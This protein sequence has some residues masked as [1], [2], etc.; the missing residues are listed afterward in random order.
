[1]PVM[2]SSQQKSLL[3]TPDKQLQFLGTSQELRSIEPIQESGY[4]QLKPEFDHFEQDP[5]Y[6]EAFEP[7]PVMQNFHR[8]G[9]SIVIRENLEGVHSINVSNPDTEGDVGPDHYFQMVKRSFMIWDKEGNVLYG[10][11]ANKTLWNDYPGPWHSMEWTDPIVIYDHLSDRWLAS[12]M[13]FNLGVEYYEM[14]AVSATADPLGAWHCYSL[15]FDKMPDY[16]KFG[17]WPDGYYLTINEYIITPSYTSFFDG[18]SILVFNRD[19]L[20]NG[21]EDPTVLYFHHE[22]PNQSISE[23]IA[24]FQPSDLDGA[25]PPEGTPNYH[26]C[27]KD[28]DWGFEQDRLWVWECVVDW[29][30]TSNSHFSEVAIIETEP[31][32]TNL[33]QTDI[34]PQPVT[35]TRLHSL[36]HF[37]MYRLQYRNFGDYEALVCN[38]TVQIDGNYHGGIRWYQL[39]DEGSG[40]YIYQQSTYVPD[41]HSRWMASMAMDL[42]GNIAIGYSLSSTEIYPSIMINGRYHYDPLNLLTF[43]ESSVVDGS[44]YQDNIPRWGDYS[45]MSVD[46]TDDFTFWYTQEYLDVSGSL[47][48]KTRVAS[49]QLHRN[50]TFSEDSLVFTTYNECIE[51]KQIIIKNNTDYDIEVSYIEPEGFYTGA[52]WYIDPYVFSFPFWLVPGDSI[53]FMVKVDFPVDDPQ[54][55]YQ[56]DTLDISTGYKEYGIPVHVNDGLMTGLK[57]SIK[58]EEN[59][60]MRV[61]PNPFTSQ[62]TIELTLDRGSKVHLEVYSIEGNL[63][64]NLVDGDLLPAG[65]YQINWE[66]TDLNGT[67]LPAGIFLVKATIDNIEAVQ[68]VILMDM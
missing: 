30:D 64:E 26:I 43:Q 23:D 63:I 15:W 20:M 4:F 57:S 17:L 22:A 27:M 68:R 54:T 35:T 48:W 16:P 50:P 34:I 24:S 38:H 53:L 46:P 8:S 33:S 61:Y 62:L 56:V 49:F 7:D 45:T 21:V 1:M 47:N 58:D 44:G 52:K 18:A 2:V 6:L 37:L 29:N 11:T 65:E 41:D 31:F 28:D 5:L 67:D 14:I 32:N 36:T 55:V 40:W 59:H 60:V 66:A 12:C 51:G 9:D 19:E 3:S 25:L 13:V 42:D 39:L 10:P